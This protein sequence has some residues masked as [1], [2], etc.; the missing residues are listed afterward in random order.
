MSKTLTECLKTWLS[1]SLPHFIFFLS[2][3]SFSFQLSISLLSS[4]V[5]VVVDVVDTTIY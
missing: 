2:S 5:V 4:G 1:D 3:T